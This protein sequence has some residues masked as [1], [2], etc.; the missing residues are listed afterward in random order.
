MAKNEITLPALPA[1]QIYRAVPHTITFHIDGAGK[2]KQDYIFE[3]GGDNALSSLLLA[4]SVRQGLVRFVGTATTSA[5][6]GESELEACNRRFAEMVAGTYK[7]GQGGGARVDTYT[8]VL[9]EC[10]VQILRN[11]FPSMKKADV[12]KAVKENIESAFSTACAHVAESLDGQS[13]QDV[14]AARWPKI[15]AH[16]KVE[17]TRRDKATGID[18]DLGDFAPDAS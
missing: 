9:R 1:D 7:P 3:F 17:A 15:E 11:N 12:I 10:V 14:F 2:V 16:A 6:E 5:K 13:E 8:I 18:F 4:A